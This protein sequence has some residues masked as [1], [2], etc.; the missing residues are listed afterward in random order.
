M[1]PIDVQLT[2]VEFS[3]I[4]YRAIHHSV[5]IQTFVQALSSEVRD[6]LPFWIT[7]PN[8]FR[9]SQHLAL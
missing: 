5:M 2:L 7:S 8:Y 4:Q 3:V 6:I 9:W 1:I